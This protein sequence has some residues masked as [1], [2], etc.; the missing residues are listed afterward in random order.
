MSLGGLGRVLGPPGGCGGGGQ[1][2]EFEGP[3][4]GAGT[5]GVGAPTSHGHHLVSV[6]GQ[7]SQ[8]DALQRGMGYGASGW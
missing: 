6:A 3:V 5:D 8:L 1:T 4:E 2:P 7:P